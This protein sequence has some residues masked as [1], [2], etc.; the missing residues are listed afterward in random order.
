ME[1]QEHDV[2]F[3]IVESAQKAPSNKLLNIGACGVAPLNF[4]TQ[5]MRFLVL[6]P[7][8][9]NSD[10]ELECTLSYEP[11]SEAKPYTA[12]VNTRGNPVGCVPIL[13][14]GK[15]ILMPRN[16]SVFL[17]H[18]RA[19][20]DHLRFWFRDL[21]LDVTNPE[22]KSRY[23]NVEWLNKMNEHAQE[24]IDLSE[25]M[26]TLWDEGKLPAIASPPLRGWGEAR[27]LEEWKRAPIHHPAPLAVQN[28]PEGSS[29]PF[30]YLPLDY[31]VDEFRVFEL[32]GSGTPSDPLKGLLAYTARAEDIPYV[33]LSYT[34]G[35]EEPTEEISLVGQPFKIRKNLAEFLRTIRRENADFIIWIDAICID[36]RNVAERIRQLPRMIDIYAAADMVVSWIGES[37]EASEVAIDLISELQTPVLRLKDDGNWDVKDSENFPRRLAALYR[38]LLRPYFRRIWVCQELAVSSSPVLFCGHRTVKWDKVDMA[39]YHL[40]DVLTRDKS[41]VDAMIAADGQLK[42]VSENDV[43]FVRRLFYFRHLEGAGANSVLMLPVNPEW[44][45]MGEKTPGILDVVV[46]ARDFESTNPYDKI[47]A[48]WNLARDTVGMDFKMDYTRSLSQTYTE[49][50][51]AE[52]KHNV[53]LDIICAA[54][55]TRNEELDM[56]SWVPDWSTPSTASSMVRRENLPNIF[57]SA[58]KNIGGPI[59]QA[60][61]KG[62]KMSRFSFSDRVLKCPGL[63]VDKIKVV[64]PYDDTLTDKRGLYAAWLGIAL[65]KSALYDWG[66]V[67]ASA[68][69]SMIAGDME[70]T[71]GFCRYD[72][73]E[74]GLETAGR[75]TENEREDG[76]SS[77]KKE[78]GNKVT[79]PESERDARKQE[80]SKVEMT[81]SLE[82]K[83][84]HENENT[85]GEVNTDKKA[86]N[87]NQSGHNP[88]E[89][90]TQETSTEETLPDQEKLDHILANQPDTST[91]D[92]SEEGYFIVQCYKPD[93]LKFSQSK[94]NIGDIFGIVTKGRRLVV[95]EKGY[96][97]LA[98]HWVKEQQSLAILSNCSTPV[99]LNE[100]EDGKYSFVGSCFVQG[101]MEGEYI[102]RESEE[103][104]CTTAE[105]FWDL[106]EIGGGQLE[107]V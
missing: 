87:E 30:T 25:V 11:L 59:Y 43:S 93:E 29:D 51:V 60:M 20:D 23:W 66:N 56:P 13:V 32:W 68:F 46:L 81:D 63:V 107:I 86:T 4:H 55:P 70:G 10:I 48:V 89:D 98:P 14:D 36:Q 2:S 72:P 90:V 50:A 80:E 21:C 34:W 65:D 7:H 76:N 67:S 15:E 31:V 12:V 42:V 78:E 35:E 52:A 6:A 62:V 91:K 104:E 92:S 40:V 103:A 84:R 39:A 97:G 5:E 88:N 44:F 16:I 41:M 82:A 79:D 95:T 77:G 33:C 58:V 24:I 102:G 61:G 19:K 53:S 17:L 100:R 37:D 57:M 9:G 54:E 22:E 69:W 64:G 105:E 96:I 101:W 28:N 1:N 8:H 45:R 75:K 38:F 74:I 99:L 26:A 49:F 47:F 71:W 94:Y 73:A 18:I 27:D 3:R 85:V 83:E 106:V